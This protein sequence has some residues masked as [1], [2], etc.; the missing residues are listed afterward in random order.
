MAWTSGRQPCPTGLQPGHLSLPVFRGSFLH[1]TR[2]TLTFQTPPLLDPGPRPRRSRDL[3]LGGRTRNGGAAGLP[4]S[5]LSDSEASGLAHVLSGFVLIACLKNSSHPPTAQIIIFQVASNWDCFGCCLLLG[6]L[7]QLE[8]TGLGSPFL[9]L[10]VV[11]HISH[12]EV[13][14]PAS[15]LGAPCSRGEEEGQEPGGNFGNV[16]AVIG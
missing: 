5:F 2:Q 15:P 7:A 6:S 4:V 14:V 12:K 13:S 11:A 10:A 8:D 16:G 1:L 9:A 3:A